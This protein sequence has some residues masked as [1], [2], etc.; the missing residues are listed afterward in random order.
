LPIFIFKIKG[1]KMKKAK[2]LTAEKVKEILDLVKTH[3]TVEKI[4]ESLEVSK[5]QVNRVILSTRQGLIESSL[6]KDQNIKDKVQAYINES[7][8]PIDLFDPSEGITEV[9]INISIKIKNNDALEKVHIEFEGLE[10]LDENG[11]EIFT[12]YVEN[13]LA[14]QI[15]EE[16]V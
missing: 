12:D 14:D 9:S 7:L 13:V 11:V 1:D 10:E 15:M 16:L 4:A 3:N 6:D 8:T 5:F 2:P